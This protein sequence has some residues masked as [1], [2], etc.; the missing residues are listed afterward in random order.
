VVNTPQLLAVIATNPGSRARRVLQDI[1]VDVAAVKR[2]LHCY[3]STPLG[4]RSRFRRRTRDAEQAHC[5]FCGRPRT[6]ALRLVAGPNVWICPDCVALCGEILTM[7]AGDRP[8]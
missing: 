3:T 2:E 5:S 4:R 8:D 1:G 7:P 6:E